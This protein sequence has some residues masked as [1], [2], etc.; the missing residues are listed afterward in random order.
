VEAMVPGARDDIVANDHVPVHLAECEATDP[1]EVKELFSVSL[2]A[3]N[4]MEEPVTLDS[5]HL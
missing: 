3:L 1:A 4:H 5:N 2:E